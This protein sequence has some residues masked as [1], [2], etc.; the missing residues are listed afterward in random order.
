MALAAFYWVF[1]LVQGTGVPFPPWAKALIGAAQSPADHRR[2]DHGNINLFIL[3][4]VIAGLYA[5]HKGRQLGGGLLLAFA[6]AC[7]LT[8]ALFVPYLVWKRSWRALVGCSLGLFL[9][10]WVVPSCFLGWNNN[11]RTV[12]Q[13]G[14]QH[15]LSVPRP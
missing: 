1:R 4:L 6:I 5:F 3:F 15:D 7:K 12:D 11:Q 10:L 9:F 2:P 13:L 8:P 14:A